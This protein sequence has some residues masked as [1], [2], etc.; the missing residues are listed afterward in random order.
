MKLSNANQVYSSL[1]EGL[2]GER[3]SPAVALKTLEKSFSKLSAKKSSSS[4][5]SR[6]PVVLLIDELDVLV[7]KRQNVL[8][9]LFDWPHQPNSFL[10]VVAIANTMDLPEKAFTNRI[11][12]R[13]GL[14]RVNFSPYTHQQL[15]QI[16]ESRL[17]DLNVFK[18]AA[19]EYCARKVAAVSGDARK[20]LDI[21]RRTIENFQKLKQQDPSSALDSIDIR[22][23]EAT[24]KEMFA[25]SYIVALKKASFHQKLMLVSFTLK[26]RQ[27]GVAEIQFG[28]ASRTTFN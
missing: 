1:Y 17:K 22:A 26:A 21:C 9:N 13:I 27:L 12:S 28:D 15:F 18:P 20:A 19:I 10:I 8:Y 23:V 2:Y 4:R 16:V 6:N 14:K 3:A 5:S 7:S 11:S 24:L 25:S